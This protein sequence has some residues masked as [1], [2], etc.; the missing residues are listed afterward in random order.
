MN[1][2]KRIGEAASQFTQMGRLKKQLFDALAKSPQGIDLPEYNANRP[3]DPAAQQ[4]ILMCMAA[5]E[6][7]KEHPELT[8]VKS[9]MRAC[10]CYRE[11]LAIAGQESG[12]QAV[13]QH[14]DKHR[15]LLRP[16]EQLLPGQRGS[17]HQK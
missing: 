11:T 7:V 4:A 12:G 9:E 15:I 13:V 3:N 14:M 17:I 10:L 8:V 2:L 16:G 6:L 1:I 5:S